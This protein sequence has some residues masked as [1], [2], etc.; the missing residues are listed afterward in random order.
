[1]L[2]GYIFGSLIC[3]LASFADKI[4]DGSGLGSGSGNVVFVP[5]QDLLQYDW[6]QHQQLALVLGLHSIYGR[7]AEQLVLTNLPAKL[8]ANGRLYWAIC[9]GLSHALTRNRWPPSVDQ[10]HY[11]SLSSSSAG[12][13][14]NEDV[15]NRTDE[16]NVAHHLMQ[17]AQHREL[18]AQVE[19][20]QERVTSTDGKYTAAAMAHLLESK[21]AKEAAETRWKQA[22]GLL[23]SLA[24]ASFCAYD[25][26][27]ARG[28]TLI[29]CPASSCRSV[30][31]LGTSF[32]TFQFR[33][34]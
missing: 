7:R 28:L 34:C 13:T 15:R 21:A 18:T 33:C 26:F 9:G 30:E 32:F 3:V 31:G 25:D 20:D 8:A 19:V 5:E 6:S 14:L 17:M 4:R 2:C 16:V 23:F 27:S 29:S 10:T 11:L 24:P 22:K 1:M 12:A